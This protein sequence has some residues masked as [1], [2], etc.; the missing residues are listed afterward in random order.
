MK[1]KFLVACIICLLSASSM[2]AYTG[3]G[4]NAAYNSVIR[5]FIESHMTSNYKKLNKVLDENSTYKIPHGQEVLV[6]SKEELVGQMKK[7]GGLVQN[8]TSNYEVL[9]KS[10]AM[11]IAR[12]DFRYDTNIQHNYLI[13]EK[14]KNLEWK[15]TQVCKIFDDVA[16]PQSKELAT[17]K[18]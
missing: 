18:N 1:N 8:C 4:D 14:D 12:V 13:L 10:D 3:P 7:D 9:A 15:I 2:Y 6:Q 16:I 5:D 11:V 17:A